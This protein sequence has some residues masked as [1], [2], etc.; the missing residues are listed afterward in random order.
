MLNENL[1]EFNHCLHY[2]TKATLQ[3]FNLK[4]IDVDLDESYIYKEAVVEWLHDANCFYN[5]V[6]TPKVGISCWFGLKFMNDYGE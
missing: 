6:E 1:K 2:H 3:Y 4:Q 5:I